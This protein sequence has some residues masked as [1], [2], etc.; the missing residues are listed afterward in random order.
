[1]QA[2]KKRL[3][4]ESDDII[5][6]DYI[7]L[8]A[9][10]MHWI[11]LFVVVA[12]GLAFLRL[13][14]EDE[15]YEAKGSIKV[16]T[17][18]NN[19]LKEISIFKDFASPRDKIITETYI[20]K[21][22]L[23]ISK[24]LERLPVQVSYFSSGRVV[25]KEIYTSSPFSVKPLKPDSVTF[26]KP[27]SLSIENEKEYIL[28]WEDE[29]AKTKSVKANFGDKVSFDGNTAWIEYNKDNFR[30]F[31]NNT[32][33]F[34]F[35]FNSKN[36]LYGR[37]SSNLFVDQIDKGVSIITISYKDVVPEFAR[38][39]VNEMSKVYTEYDITY[40]SQTATQTIEFMDRLIEDLNKTVQSSEHSMAD[41]KRGNNIL[42]IGLSNEINLQGLTDLQVNMRVLQIQLLAIENIENQILESKNATTLPISLDGKVD[43]VLLDLLTSLNK[44][45]YEKMSRSERVTPNSAGIIEINKQI[46]EVVRSIKQNIKFSKQKINSQINFYEKQINDILSGM[47]KLPD[48]EKQY[49][50]LKRDLEVNQKVYGFLLQTKLEASI[51]RASIVSSARIIDQAETP[52][53]PIEPNRKLT[54]LLYLILGLVAGIFAILIIK[55]LNNKIN[56]DE[57]IEAIC[58]LPVLGTILSYTK[59]LNENDSRLL[60]VK[61][62]RTVFG[63][64]VRAVRTNLQFLLPEK[65]SKV[66]TISSTIGGEGKTFTSINLAAS[67]TMLDKKVILL[68]CDLRK[69]QLENSFK[70]IKSVHGLS[71]Y[72]IGKSTL[73]QSILETDIDNLSVI[74]AGA[75]PPNPSELLN[76]EKMQDLLKT[77]QNTYDYILLDTPP[78]GL[79][80]DAILL[81]KQSDVVL[82]ILRAGYSQR[83]FLELPEKI[84][85]EHNIKNLYLV[86]NSL[87]IG[88]KAINRGYGYYSYG[89]KSQGYYDEYVGESSLFDKLKKKLF[90]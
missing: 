86:L 76:S 83:N 58:D 30:L 37:V 60:V 20:I 64:S 33:K 18:N 61:E 47:R 9:R 90:K 11:I 52:R 82:Y 68:G 28:S 56:S 21:S 74:L 39:V 51:S 22:K 7:K 70:V 31:K 43:P 67:L 66:I 88:K 81:M 32:N 45:H 54:F 3:K 40:K 55:L 79:V 77:L 16:D 36:N 73:E 19:L 44:L 72:L 12:L 29:S 41:F 26:D 17:E 69:P 87:T 25:Q 57:E 13:R 1:M 42:D 15:I 24:A 59:I 10:N 27:Y 84:I 34:N 50:T 48:A 38:D 35:V 63:E 2:Y 75:I 4:A 62:H 6:I 8:L 23:L 85:K 49:I 89:G 14:Y 78:I 71:S 80:S 46:D 53:E 65:K 5:L